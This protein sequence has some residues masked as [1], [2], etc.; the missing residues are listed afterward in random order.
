MLKLRILA[1]SAPEARHK[2]AQHVSAGYVMR[3]YRKRRRCDTKSLPPDPSPTPFLYL[4]ACTKLHD[5]Y[6]SREVH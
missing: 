6:S 5:R 4:C 1:C 2:L 3:K